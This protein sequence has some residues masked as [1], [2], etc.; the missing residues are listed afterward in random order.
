MELQV[1]RFTLFCVTGTHENIVDSMLTRV[2]F[3]DMTAH[4][5]LACSCDTGRFFPD[6]SHTQTGDS[7]GK[8]VPTLFAGLSNWLL[9]FTDCGGG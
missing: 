6:F 9:G 2:Y 3:L 4:C 8:T 5:K 1:N 7:N